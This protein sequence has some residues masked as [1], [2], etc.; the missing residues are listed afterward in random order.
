MPQPRAANP[1]VLFA[2]TVPFLLSP[3]PTWKEL[4]NTVNL[5]VATLSYNDSCHVG[6]VRGALDVI[7]ALGFGYTNKL[8]PV[9]LMLRTGEAVDAIGNFIASGKNATPTEAGGFVLCGL[10]QLG[11]VLYWAIIIPLLAVVLLC[12][13]MCTACGVFFYNTLCCCFRMRA[14]EAGADR[15]ENNQNYRAAP[16][17]LFPGP[18]VRAKASFACVPTSASTSAPP[19]SPPSPSTDFVVVKRNK[20][21]RLRQLLVRMDADKSATKEE[22]EHQSALLLGDVQPEV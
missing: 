8:A 21:A 9:A 20:D 10:M 13:P 6:G 14:L 19:V 11:G 3:L 12:L 1:W 7:D 4:T 22:N 5:D 17:G 15:D 2:I 18:G 16:T